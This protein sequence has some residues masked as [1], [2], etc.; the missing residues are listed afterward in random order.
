MLV[1]AIVCQVKVSKYS[2]R[3]VSKGEIPRGLHLI[4][5]GEADLVYDDLI[6][7]QVN[8]SLYCRTM[9]QRPLS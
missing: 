4:I 9:Q 1:L 8:P 3:V 7:R 2:E 6:H 5:D